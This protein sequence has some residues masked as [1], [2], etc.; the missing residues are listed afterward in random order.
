MHELSDGDSFQPQIESVPEQSWSSAGFLHAAIRGL[1]GLEVD[2][3]QHTLTLA[4][5]L[6][7]RWE[8]ISLAQMPVG[9]AQVAVTIDQHSGETDAAFTAQFGP[10]HVVFAPEIPLGA[11]NIRALI[12]GRSAPA[13]LESHAEDQHVRLAFDLPTGSAHIRIFYTGG[14]RVRVPAV[15]PARGDASRGLKLTALHLDAHSLTLDADLARSDQSSVEIETPWT[16][17]GVHGGSATRI[18]PAWYRVTFAP[19]SAPVTPS[20]SACAHHSLTVAF[21]TR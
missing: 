17:A 13:I 19:P 5:H 6:D 8:H 21:R 7:P 11:T 4:P 3:A 1:F 20:T 2:A 18:G 9:P 14:V 16:I 12:E 10:V 15:T